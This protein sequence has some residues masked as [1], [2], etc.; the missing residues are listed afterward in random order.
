[1]SIVKQNLSTRYN[2][3]E[4]LFTYVS[5]LHAFVKLFLP[6]QTISTKYAFLY[7]AFSYSQKVKIDNL[8]ECSLLK[9]TRSSLRSYHELIK[10][11]FSLFSTDTK[12]LES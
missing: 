3:P 7:D 5:H 2:T 6:F 1:M 12:N 10:R 9:G 4:Y 11:I 8:S